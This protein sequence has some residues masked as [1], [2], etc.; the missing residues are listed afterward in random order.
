MSSMPQFNRHLQNQEAIR[1]KVLVQIAFC[2][3]RRII[4]ARS[5]GFQQGFGLRFIT[6]QEIHLAEFEG[7]VRGFTVR[8]ILIY[9]GRESLTGSIEIIL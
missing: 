2:Q 1:L 7:G 5:G 6:H 4:I 8:W 9:H 3:S